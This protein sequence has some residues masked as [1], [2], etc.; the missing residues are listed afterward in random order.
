MS[1]HWTRSLFSLWILLNRARC[2]IT[3]SDFAKQNYSKNVPIKQLQLSRSSE[4]NLHDCPKGQ[5]STKIFS[6][7]ST[8]AVYLLLNGLLPVH[9]AAR[10]AADSCSVD[11]ETCFQNGQMGR[12]TKPRAFSHSWLWLCQSKIQKLPRKDFIPCRRTILES[13]T[14]VGGRNIP[15]NNNDCRK[16]WKI[17]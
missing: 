5:G 2:L 3:S 10:F 8:L 13:Q 1:W 6:L 7:Y 16:R 14:P 11:D 12:G 9:S 4:F 15:I 17:L